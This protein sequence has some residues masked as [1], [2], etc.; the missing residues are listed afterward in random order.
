MNYLT[1]DETNQFT[2]TCPIFNAET[3]MSSCVKLRDMVWK[4]KRHDKRRG[5]QACMVDSKCPVA[6]IVQ[7]ISMAGM[8]NKQPDDYGSVTPVKGKLRKDVLER[9]HPVMLLPSTLRSFDPSA[10]EIAMIESSNERI[11]AQLQSAPGAS[12]GYK[13]RSD[14]IKSARLETPKAKP[15]ELSKIEQAAATGDLSA[16]L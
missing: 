14:A 6:F 9:I 2:F 11:A 12:S 4:G 10:T 15:K 13:A 7:R 5:C 1:L 16:A 8:R 3:K